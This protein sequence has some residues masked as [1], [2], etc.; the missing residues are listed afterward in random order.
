MLMHFPSCELNFCREFIFFQF[1]EFS[2]QQ[3]CSQVWNKWC[4]IHKSTAKCV[5][6]TFISARHHLS[7]LLKKTSE[8]HGWSVIYVWQ[9]KYCVYRKHRLYE[10]HSINFYCIDLQLPLNQL[11]LFLDETVCSENFQKII[12][13]QRAFQDIISLFWRTLE[14]RKNRHI[15]ANVI[16]RVH[17]Y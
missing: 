1:S 5:C 12:R 4:H 9:L 8:F 11:M 15:V 16:G 6:S 14:K 13:S 2:P 3:W 10:F 7:I 17:V